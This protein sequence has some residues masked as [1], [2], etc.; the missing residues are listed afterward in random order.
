MD[1]IL[2]ISKIPKNDETYTKVW[3]VERLFEIL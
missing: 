1:N 3:V 2:V